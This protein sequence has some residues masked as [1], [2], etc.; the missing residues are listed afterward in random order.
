MG[1]GKIWQAHITRQCPSIKVLIHDS[2]MIALDHDIFMCDHGSFGVSSG[3]WGV[4]E[5]IN[6]VWF[7]FIQNNF[8]VLDTVL[9]DV[10]IF[11]DI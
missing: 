11:N 6:C 1:Q 8:W 9:N 3:T 5:H 4:A 7:R 10:L 2:L